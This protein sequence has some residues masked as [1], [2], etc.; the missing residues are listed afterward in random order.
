MGA[1][2]PAAAPGAADS[3]AGMAVPAWSGGRRAVTEGIELLDSTT[4]RGARVINPAD[5]V[6]SGG[7][8]R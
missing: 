8:R 5:G 7:R 2:G 4:A 6:A 1:T 3:I